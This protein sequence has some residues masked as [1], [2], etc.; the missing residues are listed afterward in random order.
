[1]EITCWSFFLKENI[2]DSSMWD[3]KKKKKGGANDQLILYA[4]LIVL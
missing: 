3:S 4:E 1:M 2:V